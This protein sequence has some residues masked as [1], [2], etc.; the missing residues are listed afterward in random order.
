MYTQY[1]R[2]YCAH[3]TQ[4]SVSVFCVYTTRVAFV[5]F[6]DPPFYDKRTPCQRLNS[7]PELACRAEASSPH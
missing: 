1:T 7:I 6:R 3:Y 4:M 5:L 2:L